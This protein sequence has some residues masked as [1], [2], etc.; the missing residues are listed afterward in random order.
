MKTR[1]AAA[2]AIAIILLLASYSAL[3]GGAA[4]DSQAGNGSEEN[5]AQ[6]RFFPS[7]VLTGGRV[8]SALAAY[9]YGVVCRSGDSARQ[10]LRSE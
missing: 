6:Q 5:V 3:V 7:A 8:V 9:R 2:A 10:A 1:I 4:T